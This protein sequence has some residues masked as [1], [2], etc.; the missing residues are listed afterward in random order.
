[1]LALCEGDS[2]DGLPP[3]EEVGKPEPDF[4]PDVLLPPPANSGA[5]IA[6]DE[7]RRRSRKLGV[8]NECMVDVLTRKPEGTRG[9]QKI[10]PSPRDI[11]SSIASIGA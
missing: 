4:E 8:R 1:M 9:I 2:D 10:S 7:K 5:V 3:E 6:N 11:P